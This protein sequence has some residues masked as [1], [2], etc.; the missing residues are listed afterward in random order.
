M[1]NVNK[2]NMVLVLGKNDF[3]YKV[4]DFNQV[5]IHRKDGKHAFIYIIL[6]I[7]IKEVLATQII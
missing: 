5:L 1:V 2:I 3:A 7:K 6:V 4:K